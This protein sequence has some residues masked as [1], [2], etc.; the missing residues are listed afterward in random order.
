[1]GVI[2]APTGSAVNKRAFTG[3]APTLE[4]AE[5]APVCESESLGVADGVGVGVG[6]GVADGIGVIVGVGDGVEVAVG[7][8]V[9]DCPATTPI[10]SPIWTSA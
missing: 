2:V 7:M 8:G 1:M 9:A 3:M 10:T 5:A 4:V 6:V